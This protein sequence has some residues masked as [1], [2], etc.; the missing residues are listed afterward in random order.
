MLVCHLRRK[1]GGVRDGV[2]PRS[3]VTLTQPFDKYLNP[4]YLKT[5]VFDVE[6]VALKDRYGRQ[7]GWSLRVFTHLTVSLSSNSISTS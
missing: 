6:K 2:S 3:H 1:M 4:N 5:I 7:F